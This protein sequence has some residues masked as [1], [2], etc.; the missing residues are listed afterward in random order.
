MK[1]RKYNLNELSLQEQEELTANKYVLN[2]FTVLAILLTISFVFNIF[3]IFIIDKKLMFS[4]YIP[5]LIIYLTVIIASL[6][7][8]LYSRRSKYFI[9]TGIIL[10]FTIIGIFLTYHSV[11]LFLFP[12]IFATLYSSKKIMCYLSVL[13]VCSTFIS[14]Y[15]GYYFG[16]C[17]ANMALLTYSNLDTH[18]VGE[19]FTLTTVQTTPLQLL[20]YYI[21]P[22]CLIYMACAVLCSSLYNILSNSLE[23]AHLADELK[24][25]MKEAE[26]AKEEAIAANHAKTLFLAKISHEIR[27]PV[28]AILG[29]NEMIFR[30]SD[31]PQIRHYAHDAKDS[32]LSM[33]NIINDILDTT[34][35]EAGMMELV[36]VKYHIGSLLNDI[37]NTIHAKAK[38]K[39]LELFFEIS[40]SIP[41]K[42]F[43]DDLRLRQVLINLLTNAV[44]YT[45]EGTVSLQL[46][47]T[48]DR[49]HARLY[50]SIKDTGVGIHA[51]DIAKLTNAYL[52]LDL[53]HN[54][55]IE[56]TG[57][58]LNIVQQILKLM[59]STLEIESVPGRGSTFA[60]SILQPIVDANPL[61]DFSNIRT[62]TDWDRP[63][64]SSFTAPGAK[65]LAVDDNQMNLNVL[66]HLLKLSK[67]QVTTA[68]SG[69]ECISLLEQN[70][71]DVIFLDHMMPQMDGIETF[72]NIK[73]RHLAPH[74]PIIMLTANAIVGS[75][76]QYLQE[77]FHDFLSKPILPERLDQMLMK[78]LP[79]KYIN[80]DLDEPEPEQQAI[81][82]TDNLPERL[83][84]LLP[85]IDTDMG[86]A[87]CCGDADFYGELLQ[88]FIA[89]PIKSELTTFLAAQ[90]APNYCTRVHGFKSNAYSV[91]AKALGDLAFKMEQLSRNNDLTDIPDLQE[92]LFAQ[93]DHICT[94]I[95]MLIP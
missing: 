5:S 70:T 35:L 50:F 43:G 69:Q 32:S 89:L 94:T 51:D 40:P 29:M 56:G 34:K 60:F 57:L 10:N 66:C 64:E 47:G 9:L 48:V 36:P 79:D 75:K 61:S 15:G 44:K 37:Y 14:V 85:E 49:G 28:N 74:T 24:K 19:Q 81:L 88:D 16:L 7:I 73:K 1:I 84:K 80:N 21:V 26:K 17:D 53:N 55:N 18:T 22:R 54:R 77:G 6:Y 72:R 82:E 3:D 42:Y 41:S 20:L 12:L 68:T 31:D 4:A 87:T 23:K 13:T 11:L 95:K 52:R 59:D 63:Y 78:H 71:Y 46:T 27:T 67:V 33:L 62:N 91:G 92:Q 76:E 58:G 83:N 2:C 38:E 86:L 90:D 93:Y 8:P 45:D 25:A 39:G 30:E 65:V